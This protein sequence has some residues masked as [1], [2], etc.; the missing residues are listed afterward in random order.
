M[1]NT[2]IPVKTPILA[3]IK[4]QIYTEDELEKPRFPQISSIP[5]FSAAS[6]LDLRCLHRP[7][8]SNI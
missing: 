2:V 1:K 7:I 6:D 4:K 3:L 5:L 8:F